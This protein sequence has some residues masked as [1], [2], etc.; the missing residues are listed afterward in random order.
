MGLFTYYLGKVQRD[1]VCVSLET[2]LSGMSCMSQGR[3]GLAPE[4][5]TGVRQ[6]W[7][8]WRGQ[9]MAVELRRQ[10]GPRCEED[11]SAGERPRH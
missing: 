11:P 1:I 2:S 7:W 4:L 6:C 8:A 9:G 5:L 10:K 3:Q